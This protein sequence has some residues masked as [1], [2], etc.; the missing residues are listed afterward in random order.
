MRTV[1]YCDDDEDDLLMFREIVRNVDQALDVEYSNDSE[2]VLEIL[3][4]AAKLPDVIFLDINMPRVSGTE[5]LQE[6]KLDSKLSSIPVYMYSTTREL[7]EANLCK[8]LGAVDL[9]Q[10]LPG[11]DESVAQIKT[12][13]EQL[14]LV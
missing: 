14:Q 12:A 9:L 2:T 6:L 1:F 3:R 7:R 13:L 4:A 10:K 8:E 11:M 5:L